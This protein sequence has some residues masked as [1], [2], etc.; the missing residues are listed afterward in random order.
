MAQETQPRVSKSV[1]YL[2]RDIAVAF[3]IVA[4]VMAAIFA[5]TRV[6]PPMVVVESASIQHSNTLSFV[7]V[8][9]TGDLVLVQAVSGK[10]DVMTYLEGRGSGYRTYGDYGD[11]IIFLR[12]GRPDETPIIHRAMVYLQCNATDNCATY[13]VPALKDPNLRRGID[14]DTTSGRY[15]A[16]GAGEELI[17]R[18]VGF[19]EVTLTLK[20]DLFR[21]YA[22][23]QNQNSPYSGYITMG[24]N[25]ARSSSTGVS[26][27]NDDWL[28][29]QDWIIGRA[30]GELPWFGL[31]KLTIEAESCRGWGDDCAPANSWNALTI[32]LVLLVAAPLSVDVGFALWRRAERNRRRIKPR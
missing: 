21:S 11:V 7:G 19:R 10:T 8:V 23:S 20:L 26:A 15:L 9:D 29:K 28:V 13:D 22:I 31:I 16:L 5:Y 18:G 12:N 30:R 14:W 17:L 3:L 4:V 27:G 32:S 24:D 1:L 25:N 2:L 6:W